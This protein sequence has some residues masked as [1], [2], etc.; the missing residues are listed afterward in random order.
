MYLLNVEN[1]SSG[2]QDSFLLY[3]LGTPENYTLTI[4]PLV[5]LWTNSGQW[6]VKGSDLNHFLPKAVKYP[7]T[8]I[9]SLLFHSSDLA[10]L[11]SDGA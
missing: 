7:C 11:S 9:Q 8:K 3:F 6:I 1:I 4:L 2:H 5:K 10:V